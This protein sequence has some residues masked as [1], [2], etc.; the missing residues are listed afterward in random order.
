VGVASRPGDG[1]LKVLLRPLHGA[2]DA[3]GHFHAAAFSYRPLPR[4]LVDLNK[5]IRDLFEHEKLLGILHVIADDRQAMG[6]SESAFVRG[7]CWVAPITK[8]QRGS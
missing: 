4:G 5:T 6:V 3:A 8:V 7:A 1:G 2:G